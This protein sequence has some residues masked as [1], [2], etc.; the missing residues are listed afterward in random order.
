MGLSAL[1]VSALL[2]GAGTV[3]I[4]AVAASR[5]PELLAFIG[6]S[7]T[8]LLFRFNAMRN[9]PASITS[10]TRAILIKANLATAGVFLSF[11]LALAYLV[12]SQAATIQ[13]GIAPL[14]AIASERLSGVPLL[15]RGGVRVASTFIAA[16]LFVALWS[17]FESGADRVRFGLLLLGV[18]LASLSGAATAALTRY[19]RD[20]VEAGWSNPRILANRFYAVIVLAIALFLYRNPNAIRA[21]TLDDVTLALPCFFFIA[22]P[23]YL[24]QVG[25]AKTNILVTLF[26]INLVPTVTLLM[27]SMFASYNWSALS[28]IATILTTFGVFCYLLASVQGKK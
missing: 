18:V 16:G 19:L 10:R 12:P 28:V 11:Y 25:I 26:S 20:L 8:A 24:L 5:P 1:M 3:W 15:Q 9:A 21:P 7:L 23:I 22:L 14:A 27:Q 17:V 2:M 6:F 13:A 4:G